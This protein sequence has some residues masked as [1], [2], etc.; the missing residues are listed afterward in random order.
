MHEIANYIR[1]NFSSS[2]GVTWLKKT[3]KSELILK[4]TIKTWKK[5]IHYEKLL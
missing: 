3:Q 4:T 2:R 5:T 1:G